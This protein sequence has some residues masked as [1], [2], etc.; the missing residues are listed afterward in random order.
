[1]VAGVVNPPNID[2]A[3]EDLVRS[4][5]QA[6]WLTET[7]I[8]LGP[9]VRDVLDR[10]KPD[11]L[12]LLDE[13]STQIHSRP[14]AHEAQERSRRI[15]A[16]LTSDLAEN[17]AP[18]YT[19][20]WLANAMNS[21]QRRFDESF[22]RWRSLFRATANQMKFANSIVN[23]AAATEQERREA[24]ARYDEAFTQQSLLLGSRPTMNS[25]FYTY[26][27]LASEGFLPG[28]NFPRLPLMA[29]I[30]GR[31]KNV[32]RDAFLSRPRFLG[33]T[34]FGPQSI[35]YHEGSTYRVRRAILSIRDESGVTV[36]A[37]L[38][39][40]AARVCPGCGYGHFGDQQDYERCVNCAERLDGG[41]MIRN[42]YRIEQVSTRRANRITSDEEERQRQGYEMI[43]TLRFSEENGRPRAEGI[44][45]DEGGE[46]LLELR[47]GPA[48]MLWRIN[49][50]WRR[51]REPS[52][53]G[54]TVDTNTG[55]WTK[56][57]Q[58][59]TDA[60]DD[61]VRE[62][63]SVERITPFVEDTRNVLL[64]RPAVELSE[65]AMVSLQFAIKRGIEQEFQ[66]EEAELA[67]EPLPDREH[68]T[69]ILLY[70]SAEGG[71]GVLT[72]IANDP[73]ALPRIAR[74]AMEVCHWESISGEWSGFSDL[75][76]LDDNCEAGC[77]RCLLSYYNQPEHRLID[78]R[79]E[80]MLELLCRLARGSRRSLETEKRSAGDSF[81]ELYNASTSSLEKEWL[82]FIESNGYCLPDRVQPLIEAYATR[83]DFGYAGLQTLIY[84]DGPHHRAPTRQKADDVTTR[85]LSDGGF[86][87]VRFPSDRSAWPGIIADF[88]WVFGTG[89]TDRTQG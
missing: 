61:T 19:D 20:T 69:T 23:N 18:W 27:Y 82:L 75:R 12:P 51:R 21:V 3:N 72:R 9:S 89:T 49:L 2:L 64:I 39:V 44:A 81:E 53:Y 55:E 14:A 34:E 63:K 10:E 56:D 4:H 42:L 83:A 17:A 57:S 5:L 67:A 46:T 30:P 78:R 11:K 43:T 71:A 80:D 33:L 16:T 8:K 54:F 65:T 85:R 31:R 1:M 70:E 87:V 76:N 68:R 37:S 32:T 6:V 58:A 66:L 77:Y 38:P 84:I 26:R 35:I 74:R 52:V 36:S 28:Y 29:F 13:I 25:D 45:I 79:D 73:G 62:G 24:K 88:A 22:G 48:A 41:R 50:G 86:T 7:G 60:E 40:Q 47:Y 15:L 59:P